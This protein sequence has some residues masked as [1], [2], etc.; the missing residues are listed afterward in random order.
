MENQVYELLD[1]LNINYTKIEHPPLFSAKDNEK[2]NVKIDA[3]VCKNLFLRNNNKSQ[4]YIV[5]LP[6]EK[7]ANLKLIQEELSESRLS[8]GDEKTLVKKLGI[9]PGSVSIFNVTNPNSNDIIFLLDKDLLKSTKI[10][11]H[12]NANTA[13]I[14]FDSKELSRIFDFYNVKYKFITVA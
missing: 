13:T 7:R 2:Y 4:Y 12:P 14:I 9:K 6:L 5:A 10:G 3:L 1:N 11:F 8:F